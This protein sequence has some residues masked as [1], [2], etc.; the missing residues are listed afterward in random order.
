MTIV[1]FVPTPF[2]RTI[3]WL[4]LKAVRRFVIHGNETVEL[5]LDIL[6][7]VCWSVERYIERYWKCRS[8]HIQYNFIKKTTV[9]FDLGT[10]DNWK[11]HM[12][13]KGSTGT[14]MSTVTRLIKT[15]FPIGSVGHIH[16]YTKATDQGHK[17]KRLIQMVNIPPSH[18]NRY[19]FET[20][21]EQKDF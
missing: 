16:Q 21:V 20:S 8:C 14:G 15:M 9:L 7:D 2:P 5:K 10:Y 6:L 12:C 18:V 17:K 19:I 1:G 11:V 4:V 13:L 3:E